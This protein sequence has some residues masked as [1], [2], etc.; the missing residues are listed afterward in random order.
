MFSGQK[1]KVLYSGSQ[2]YKL[3]LQPYIED[4][5]KGPCTEHVAPLPLRQW[6]QDL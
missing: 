3:Q 5:F 6:G 1:S 4:C 2:L